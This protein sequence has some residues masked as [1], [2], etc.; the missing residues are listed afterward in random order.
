[1]GIYLA[2]GGQAQTFIFL[3]IMLVVLYLFI[4]RP[5]QR[6]QRRQ[7]E[8]IAALKEG[9]N[10]VTVGGIHGKIIQLREK[11]VVIEVDKG[12]KLTLD[13]ASISYDASS[14]SGGIEKR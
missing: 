8:Y 14:R 9:H 10:V 6:R 2:G 7:R 5:Q 1:M 13:R 12:T 4:I 11:E 3:G